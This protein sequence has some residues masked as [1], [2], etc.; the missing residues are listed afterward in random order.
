MKNR[1]NSC[2]KWL[3]VLLSVSMLPTAILQNGSMAYAEE[4]KQEEAVAVTAEEALENRETD[5]VVEEISISDKE[6]FLK[7]ARKCQDDYYSY[8]RVFNL[9]DD[10][11]LSGSSFDGIPYFAGTFNGNGHTVS[12]LK[13]SR[14]GSDYGFFRYVGKT[15]RVKDLTVSGSVKVTGSA[16]NVGGF[17]GTNYGIL[18]NCSFEGIVTGNTNVGGIVGENRAD[19]IVLT[20]YNKGT[21]GGTNEVGGICGMNRGILQNCENEGKINDEDLK[22]TLDLNGIDIGTLNLTQN[23]VTRND[24]GGIAGRSS[25][26]VADC[27]NKGE[28]GYAHIGYNVGGVIGRQSGTVINCKNMGHVMGRKDVGGIIGQA[29]PYRESEYLSDHLEKVRDDFSEINHLM[30][31]MSDAMRSVSS[32]TRGYVQTLQ[33]QYED[34]MGNL[35]SEIN[36]MKSTVTGNNAAM[37]A[38]MDSLSSALNNLGE[39][40]N[41]TISRMMESIRQNTENAANNINGKLNDMKDILTES[42][43]ESGSASE[44]DGESASESSSPEESSSQES[45]SLQESPAESEQPSSS[46]NGDTQ[47]Q[48]SNNEEAAAIP[49][50]DAAEYLTAGDDEAGDYAWFARDSVSRE[51]SEE[52]S[53]GWELPSEWPSELPSTLPSE[54]PSES[55]SIPSQSEVESKADAITDILKKDPI[56]VNHDEKIDDNLN[57]MK[58]EIS[59]ASDNIKNLQ[60]TL[61][62]TGDSLTN[63]MSNISGELTDQSKASGDTID[64]MTDSVD[65]GIQSITSDLDR[66]LNTS[67]RITDIISDDVNVL[68]GNGSAIDDVS[69]KAL[70]ERTLGVVSGCSNHGKIEGDINAGGIAGIMNTEYDVDP[71][72]D[73]DLTE[74]TDVEVRSTTNDVLIHCINYG[75][76][77]GKKRNSGGIAGSEELGLIHTCENYGTVQLEAGN[78]LGGIAGYSVSRVNQ[79]YALCNLKGDNKI[80]G[81]TGEGYD[82]SNCLAMV[83]ISGNRTEKIGSIAGCINED[84]TLENN[85]FVSD[86]WGGVDQINYIGKAQRCTY[87]ELMQMETVPTGFTQVTVTFEQDDEVLATLQIPYDGTVT[88]EEVPD[89]EP[90]EDCYIS[91]DRKFPLTHVTANVTVTAESKRFTKSLAWFSTADQLKPDFLVEGD[92]YDTSVLS[93][94]SVQADRISDG[95]PVYA[96]TWNIDNM[97]E[98]KEEY[99]LHLRIPDGADSAVV[100]I[101]TENK[102]EKA[103]TEEDGS[104]VT[105][106]VPYGTAFAVYSVQ[107]N[108]VPIWLILAIAAAAVLA[109]F[110][111]IK[112]IR[113]GK[114]R[115]KKRREKRKKKK[116]QQT[117]SQ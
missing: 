100:R 104:Y 40:G 21:I 39:I 41:D 71:E 114:N 117:D 17:V 58:G 1:T 115:V 23:V 82:I 27:T 56:K 78:G 9:Q 80:G 76:V 102:W 48:S 35:D 86:L 5:I 116:Q 7:F 62:G 59:S 94:E 31:Q 46:E 42:S 34:T 63:T 81:I 77:A 38:Y 44:S 16:E 65:G 64:S 72:V 57:Q 85:Y 96:Y 18:E 90:D 68:L 107:D 112:A 92:F 43:S 97:P 8:G 54:L 12:G 79:S 19:G 91:W 6:E 14:E 98:Q 89:I 47:N 93:A 84:G 95:D 29:E 74:L 45:S 52:S 106:S 22:T 24:A 2:K 10:I 26:T 83:T 25:G 87:E 69:G 11:D 53:S 88:E 75:T 73:M 37:T 15:G 55:I 61:T 111:I 20:C 13:I 108:S 51:S 33:Q 50:D 103:D 110:L 4:K 99:V 36:S 49:A 30:G 109:T 3:A 113:R 101:Q 105:V 70:T 28:I 32:D 60:N 66:I 67:S